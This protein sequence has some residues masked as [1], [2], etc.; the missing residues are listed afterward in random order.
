MKRNKLYVP[1]AT[2]SGD[3]SIEESHLLGNQMA[4]CVTEAINVPSIQLEYENTYRPLLVVKK[5]Q[6]AGMS[7]EPNQSPKKVIKGLKSMRSDTIPVAKN[8]QE[9]IIDCIAT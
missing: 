6:S 3:I 5:G 8:L 2:L 4:Q 7:Y 9:K 1:F